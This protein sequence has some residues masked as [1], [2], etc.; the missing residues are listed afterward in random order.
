MTNIALVVLDTLRKDAF[1]RH[2]EWLPGRRFERAYS[3]ANWT[4]PAHA[5]LF[6]GR[7]A[8]EVGIH[9]K[10]TYC[11]SPE[12]TLAEQLASTGYTT[13][14]FSANTNIT[15]H[16]G[17]DRG[18][19]DFRAPEQFDHLNDDDLFDW[20]A[21]SRTTT[22][23]GTR[24]Y[25]EAVRRCITDDVRT[26]RSLKTGLKL[27][28]TEGTGVEH[29]G[30]REAIAEFR[31]TDFG[32]Q[33]FL[34]LNLMEAHEPYTAPAEY[35]TVEQPALTES[36]GDISLDTVNGNRTRRAYDDCARYL[37]DIY[38]ELFDRLTEE[39]EYVITLSDHGEML[40]EG[41][42]WGHEHGVHPELTH[43]P[44]VVSGD[45]ISG[46]CSKT[47]NLIDVYTTVLQLADVDVNS[48]GQN[49]AGEVIGHESLTEFLGLTSWSERKLR[50]NGYEDRF[51][52]YDTPL[53]GY[54]SPTTYYGY[55]S[56][57][58]FVESG[59]SEAASSRERLGVLVD[60]LDVRQVKR[61]NEVPEEVREQ[62]EQLGY[63]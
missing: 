22:A 38:C 62:L 19:M 29:G 8:S 40:G 46:T 53:R 42:A 3:T 45:G 44:L 60:E 12:P 63:A 55:E 37:A 15:G 33:E 11:D 9:A 30:T 4:V 20:R 36:V 61:D 51:E 18:F 52:R 25:L 5:S 2:F 56:T 10:N 57:D 17:F 7:Y 23:A 35:M 58:G 47:V 27:K 28:L 49:L 26:I 16:F 24:K 13:R 41:G 59:E 50:Q 32:N 34:F 14:A 39:F 43:V 54:A 6:T 31:N 48:H 21:F 1:D